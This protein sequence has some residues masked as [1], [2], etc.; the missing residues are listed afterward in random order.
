MILFQKRR[1]PGYEAP[2]RPGRVL[3][4]GERTSI[5]EYQRGD[6][7]RWLAWPRHTDPMF[8]SYNPPALTPRQRD[9]YFTQRRD[10]YDSRQFS[11]YAHPYEGGA[12]G[13]PPYE[14][15][16]GGVDEE[17]IGRI[18]LRDIDWRCRAAVL[19]I[20][21]HPERLDSGLGTDALQAFLGY[22]FACLHMET[23]FLD[24]AAFNVRACRVYEKCGFR[25]CGQRW[26]E[27]QSDLAGI[28]SKAEFEPVRH[29]FMWEFG[30]V[31]PLLLDMVLR[32]G[33]W[34]PR[35]PGA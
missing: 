6:I 25:R 27:P 8:E 2:G 4:C 23:L 26:G 19:G 12:G 14:G 1:E 33:D 7:D 10:A 30:L 20:S 13:S 18:S 29:L 9:Q 34:T 3:T 31:R 32:R 21:L 24:V 11:I 28:F 15:G 5:R 17:L 22:Y 16:A 35:Q